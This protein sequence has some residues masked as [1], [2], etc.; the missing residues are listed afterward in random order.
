MPFPWSLFISAITCLNEWFV[1]RNRMKGKGVIMLDYLINYGVERHVVDYQD[2]DI[3]DRLMLQEQINTVRKSYSKLLALLDDI[4]G[5][6]LDVTS[7]LAS[8]S[9]EIITEYQG[10]RTNIAFNTNDDY[11]ELEAEQQAL[12]SGMNMINAQIDYCK[13]DLRILNSVFYNKF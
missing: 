9:K 4:Q 5:K 10:S 6:Y 3:N 1:L 2:I 12:K 8:K 7:R 11:I 13:N